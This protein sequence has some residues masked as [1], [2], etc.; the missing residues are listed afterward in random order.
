LAARVGR[1]LGH[2][3]PG[4]KGV[5]PLASA[6]QVGRTQKW[7]WAASGHG[8]NSFSLL[9]F[10][11]NT[12][13]IVSCTDF[14]Q[15]SNSFLY[16]NYSNESLF[17]ECKSYRNFSEKFKVYEFYSCFRCK[18]LK[19]LLKYNKVFKLNFLKDVIK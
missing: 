17:R 1:P 9:F 12:V 16:S 14:E 7:P 11:Q 6:A 3:G 18:Y 10:P 5:R 4:R 13:L 15:I 8:P 2:L 19:K